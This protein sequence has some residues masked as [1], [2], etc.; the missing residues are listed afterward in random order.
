MEVMRKGE[1]QYRDGTPM[2]CPYCNYEYN[3]YYVYAHY[4]DIFTCE[5]CKEQSWV[6]ADC[7]RKHDT[8]NKSVV[9]EIERL[10]NSRKR[11][12]RMVI[13]PTDE[14]VVA[15][16]SQ[17][18]KEWQKRC[19]NCRYQKLNFEDYPCIYCKYN[20]VTKTKDMWKPEE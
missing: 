5:K 3:A 19:G 1:Y 7:K 15:G 10:C 11:G 14:V 18:K 17:D 9:D 4:K 6:D 12:A 2:F 20:Q 8:E 16:D 13:V